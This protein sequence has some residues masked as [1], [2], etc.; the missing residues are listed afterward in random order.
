VGHEA[1]LEQHDATL[2]R[3]IIRLPQEPED[4]EIQVWRDMVLTLDDYLV[5]R[6]LE[7]V[8]HI[9]DLAV[10]LEIE[11]PAIPQRAIDLTIATLV[12]VARHKHGDQA[13]LR[14]MTRR[15]RD[16]LNALRVF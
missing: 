7:M 1:L 9:D 11:P 3:L 14:A 8:V 10:S 15:E 6:I 13:V 2:Q 5:T 4:R 12:D 16:T